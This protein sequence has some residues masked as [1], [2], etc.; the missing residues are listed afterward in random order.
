T[1][2]MQETIRI[3]DARG[4]PLLLIEGNPTYDERFGFTRADAAGIE[5]PPRSGAARSIHPRRS[6][7]L[8]A[9]GGAEGRL[10]GAR[11]GAWPSPCEAIECD[12]QTRSARG[13]SSFLSASVPVHERLPF[14]IGTWV[15]A[16]ELRPRNGGG[17]PIPPEYTGDMAVFEAPE[18][19]Q[20]LIDELIAPVAAYNPEVDRDLIRRAF[21]FAA[22]ARWAQQGRSA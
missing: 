6:G 7:S 12:E 22:A 14:S 20:G 10:A 16:L 13:G 3:A 4:E 18:K 8:L 2:L 21:L 17:S 1:A 5:P 15:P 11:R 9:G 19:H